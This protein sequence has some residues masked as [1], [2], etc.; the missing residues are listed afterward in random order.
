MQLCEL[1]VLPNSD[2]EQEAE[3][4]A[5]FLAVQFLDIFVGPHVGEGPE[6][7]TFCYVSPNTSHA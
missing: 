5:L 6:T 4:I 2:S 3:H 7:P 1:T